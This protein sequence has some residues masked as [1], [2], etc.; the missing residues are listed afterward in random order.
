MFSRLIDLTM[1][2]S[3]FIAVLNRL[4]ICE[5]WACAK[6]KPFAGRSVRLEAPPVRVT[7]TVTDQGT[8]VVAPADTVAAVTLALPADL[9]LRVFGGGRVDTAAVMGAAHIQGPADFAD[10]L[11]FVLRHLRWDAE[12]DLAKLT[13]DIAAHRLIG[14][15]R[16]FFDWQR[17]S[18]LNFAENMAEYLVEEKPSVLGRRA[19]EHFYHE[20]DAA[21]AR[22]TPLEQRIASLETAMRGRGKAIGQ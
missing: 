8:F 4:V 6:L 1:L 17:R 21:T 15:A 22:V 3:P 16:R 10:S 9:P 11:G 2:Y 12:G 5:D 13:G 14:A 19:A 7:L 18:A 20:I